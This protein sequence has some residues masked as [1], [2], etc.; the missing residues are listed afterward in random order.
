M[1]LK[2]KVAVVTG[3]GRGLGRSICLALAREGSSVVVSD[4]DVQSAKKVACEVKEIGSEAL[5]IRTDVTSGKEVDALMEAAAEDSGRVDIL[6]NNAGICWVGKVEEMSEQDWDRV[7]A[8]NLKGTFLCSKAVIKFMKG[9][10]WGRIVNMASAAGKTGGLLVGANYSVSKAG[11]ICFTKSL[12]KELAPYGITVNA[13]APGLIDTDMT[14]SFPK[15]AVAS[16]LK[17]L[18]LGRMGSS[19]DVARAVLFLISEDA[20]YITGE[21]LDVNGGM[22]MD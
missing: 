7:M 15:G 19:E 5:A 9:K 22:V 21:I 18:P 1:R 10:G 17:S 11:V 3:G 16:T 2:D 6:V 8:V 12:A 20:G 13:V 14:R 4:I